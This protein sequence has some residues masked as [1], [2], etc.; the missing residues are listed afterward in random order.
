MKPIIAIEGISFA[1][2]TT[3][4]KNLAQAGFKRMYE[5]S[6]KFGN[7]LDFPTFPKTTDEAKRSDA[8]FLEQEI[9]RAAE[10][11]I[12]AENDI[13]IA[14]RSFISGLAFAYARQK[15]YCLG[16]A[17]YQHELIRK[18]LLSNRLYVPW[19]IYLHI[20]INTIFD[21]KSRDYERRLI[22]YGEKAIKNVTVLEKEEQFFTEQIKYY[23]SIFK[24]IP[25]LKLDAKSNPSKLVDIVKNLATCL[26][27]PLP[28][29]NIESLF[30][31][32]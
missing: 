24:K 4:S 27:Q 9:L 20:D 25:H 11:R 14:D 3:L 10:A 5:L 12:Y 32:P 29:L 22:N 26:S 28:S 1:G 21:R 15:T 6:E 23:E 13:I 19:L 18:A 31:R 17:V 8:W 30:I 2:K 16:N 7:G